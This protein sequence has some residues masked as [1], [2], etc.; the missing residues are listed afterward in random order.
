MG[1]T[2]LPSGTGMLFV[3]P[4]EAPRTFWMKNT[5]IPLDML[6]ISG[7]GHINSIAHDVRPCTGD[8]CP[9]RESAQDSRYV[10]EIAGGEADQR[11]IATGDVLDVRR[12]GLSD[13]E[14]PRSNP[15]VP[16]SPGG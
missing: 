9:F 14:A 1:R 5:L 15:R 16:P 7:D 8:P 10:L 12:L 2:S 4:E 6:F 3:F 11:G 13:T